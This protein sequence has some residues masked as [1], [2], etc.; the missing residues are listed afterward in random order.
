MI[1]SVY[2]TNRIMNKG[3]VVLTHFFLTLNTYK[4]MLLYA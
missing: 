4:N 2:E 3:S 1:T